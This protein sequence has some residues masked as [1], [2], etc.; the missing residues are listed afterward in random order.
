MEKTTGSDITL[1]EWS[2]WASGAWKIPNSSIGGAKHMTPLAYELCRRLIKLYSAPGDTVL[3]P[4]AGSGTVNSAAIENGRNAIGIELNQEFYKAA[5][6]IFD[7]W[8]DSVY[9]SNDSY[10]NMISRF[11]EQLA[12]GEINKDK[13]KAEKE[14][15][16][17]MTDKKKE[18]QSKIK[19]LEAELNA[20]GLKKSEIKK[21][22]TEAKE[23]VSE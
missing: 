8:D 16:K 4:F 21:I 22:R 17:E 7:K 20:L 12:I 3:D 11:K 9:E 1:E 23:G 10:E 15:K 2:T 5:K 6:E 13:A 19:E 18:L 14:E